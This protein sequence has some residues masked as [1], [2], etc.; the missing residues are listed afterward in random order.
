MTRVE[1]MTVLETL[2]REHNAQYG[3][4]WEDL[5]YHIKEYVLGP[6]PLTKAELKRF[7]ERDII[8]IHKIQI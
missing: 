5:T 8:T 6:R 4:K 3:I 2:H 7:V 1:A